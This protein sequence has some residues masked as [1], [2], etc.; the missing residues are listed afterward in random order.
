MAPSVA[1]IPIEILNKF[2]NCQ[3]GGKEKAVY[4]HD[5]EDKETCPIGVKQFLYC[6]EC[7]DKK[8]HKHSQS[9]IYRTV[10][11]EGLAWGKLRD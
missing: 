3:C 2:E 11:N 9:K 10:I 6:D 4:Y 5:D 7:S 1:S 8:I